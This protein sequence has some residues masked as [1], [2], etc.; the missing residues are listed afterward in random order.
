MMAE[1]KPGTS[2]AFKGMIRGMP[3]ARKK[4]APKLETYIDSEGR[5]RERPVITPPRNQ[6]DNVMAL[7][8]AVIRA[9][10]AYHRGEITLAQL[11]AATDQYIEAVTEKARRLWPTRKFYKPSRAYILRA[12]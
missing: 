10:S 9:R 4:K 8:T 2:S 1:R 11:Y 6:P 5:M 12:L 3:L 7:R